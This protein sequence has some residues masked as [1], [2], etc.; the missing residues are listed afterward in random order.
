MSFWRFVS[1]LDMK[2]RMA[3]KAEAS[4][5]YLSYLW[6]A[7]EPL[8]WVLVFYFVFTVLLNSGRDVSF[9]ICGK[10]PFL[11]FSKSVISASNS[12]MGSRS[13]L[14]QTNMS[15]LFFPYQA[16][17][18]VLYKQWLVFLVLFATVMV[19]GHYPS[20]DWLWLV[21]LILVQYLLIV[22][23][24]LVG[25]LLVS[26][27]QD[28]R[29]LINMGMMFLLFSSGIFWDIDEIGSPEM[30]QLV[31]LYNPL[32]FLIDAYR[33]VLIDNGDYDLLHLTVLGLVLL[34]AIALMHGLYRWKSQAIAYRVINS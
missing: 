5:L 31:R 10:V 3:L 11:W 34:T 7:L 21:P 18:E 17:Q 1:L 23:C 12:I 13:L 30:A 16:L 9:L 6:W 32:A 8:L 26:Y 33:S 14:F 2:S 25:A 22:L 27:A 28:V 15:K 20:V 24:A 29:I 19:Y 4:K